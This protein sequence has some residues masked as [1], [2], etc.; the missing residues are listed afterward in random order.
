MVLLMGRQTHLKAPQS[1]SAEAEVVSCCRVRRA[2]VAAVLVFRAFPDCLAL[3]RYIR[4]GAAAAEQRGK[5][6]RGVHD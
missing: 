2:A 3:V 1:S 4:E 6:V 5:H